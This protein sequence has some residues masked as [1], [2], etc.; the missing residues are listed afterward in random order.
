MV[1]VGRLYQDK[2]PKDIFYLIDDLVQ[3]GVK[4]IR[5]DV[6][7]NGLMEDELKI[8][9]KEHGLESHISMKGYQTK[10]DYSRYYLGFLPSEFEA[11]ART[12][13]EYMMNG[14]A[15]IGTKTGGTKEQILHENTG[16]LYAPG[17]LT[18]LKNCVLRLYN[19]RDNC[20]LYGVNG[21]ERVVNLFSQDKYVEKLGKI[22]VDCI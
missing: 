5:L 13:L 16:Y 15:V 22:F 12:T 6:Y 3:S 19:D 9:V 8:F 2:R 17:D 10:I 1:Y 14:L 21:Y 18:E 7:G 20:L 4:D 11:F